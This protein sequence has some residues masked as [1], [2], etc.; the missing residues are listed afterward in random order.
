M[1]WLYWPL[2]VL[3]GGA[4]AQGQRAASSHTGAL[5]SDDAIF[6]GVCRQAGVI[7][8]HTPEEAFEAAAAFATQ[9]LPRGPRT[10]IVTQAGGWGVLTADACVRAGLELIP[11]PA[12]LRAKLDSM[13]PARWSRGNPI[14][15][16]GGETRETVPE[17]LELAAAQPEVDAVLYLGMGIQAAQGHAYKSGPFYPDYG[18]ERIVAFQ[19]RQDRRY[20]LAAAEVSARH[21]K[22]VLVATDLVYTDRPYGNAGPQGVRESGHIG[23]PS[24]NRAVRTL[25]QMLRYARWRERRRA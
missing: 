6:E 2:V 5:A 20:A 17:V 8:A 16:A 13:V 3:R 7:R 12:D 18:L 24:G 9:P 10:L 15:F 21:E 25:S 1:T 19:E 11:L 14:D 4:T 22:P 23:W